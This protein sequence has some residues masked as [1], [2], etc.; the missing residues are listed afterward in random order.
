MKLRIL[1]V[2]GGPVGLFQALELA[3]AGHHVTVVEAS[4]WPRDKV[5]GEGIMPGGVA[6]LDQMGVLSKL[7]TTELSLFK[8]VRYIDGNC[9]RVGFFKYGHGLGVRRTSLSQALFDRASEVTNIELYPYTQL[10]GL[11]NIEGS[12]VTAQLRGGIHSWCGDFVI[13]ADGINSKTRRLLG[14]ETHKLSSDVRLGARVHL[15]ANCPTDVPTE[16][17]VY[18][19]NGVEAYL[20]PNSEGSFEIAFLWFKDRY[21]GAASELEAW[22]WSQFPVLRDKFFDCERLSRFQSQGGFATRANKI[23]GQNWALVGDAAYFFDGI[24]GEGLSLGFAL[25]RSLS[26]ALTSGDLERYQREAEALVGHN[27]YLTKLALYL[28]KSPKLRPIALR[29]LSKPVMSWLVSY[30]ARLS[31]PARPASE[32]FKLSSKRHNTGE[33]H[34]LG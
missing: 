11:G 31:T 30:A 9:N 18:W 34:Y 26:W 10:S 33:L 7:P 28:A 1:V 2:G 27:I 32:L 29:V 17:E 12:P 5:C 3:E 20:T 19:G 25:A 15:K 14:I 16:V 24:T 23:M 8:G 4:D 22:L 6:L 13:G 21:Q